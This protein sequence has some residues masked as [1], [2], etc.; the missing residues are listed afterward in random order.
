MSENTAVA[1]RDKNAGKDEIYVTTTGVRLRMANIPSSVSRAISMGAYTPAIQDL[2]N[3]KS[4]SQ[5]AMQEVARSIDSFYTELVLWGTEL[6]DPLPEDDRWLRRLKRTTSLPINWSAY[7]DEN[8]DI[9]EEGQ[10]ELYV[11]YIA[12]A[13]DDDFDELVERM[14]INPGDDDGGDGS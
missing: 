4:I 9:G 10:K 5:D 7:E 14:N 3:G 12:L 8:G 6:M 1:K 11:R 2:R 13:N